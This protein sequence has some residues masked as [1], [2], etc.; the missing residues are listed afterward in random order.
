[1]ST[2]E[3]VEF[4]VD[5]CPCGQGK[6]IK[7]VTTQ[8][9]PWSKADIGYGI[10]C[11][12]CAIEW[13]FEYHRSS[14]LV[15]R[16][17]EIPYIEASRE[18]DATSKA[19]QALIDPVVDAYFASRLPRPMTHE[20]REMQALGISRQNIKDYRQARKQ[21]RKHS[22]L[23]CALKN[24]DWLAKLMANKGN[25]DRFGS[26][27]SEYERTRSAASEARDRIVRYKHET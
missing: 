6:I 21:G 16:A 8:D 4:E 9:N 15:N 22:E 13:R 18:E 5:A 17:S 10:G 1:M 20:L 2:S 26:L 14:G 7:Y 3:T 24:L 19:L 11:T 23:T 27:R 12:K 25:M